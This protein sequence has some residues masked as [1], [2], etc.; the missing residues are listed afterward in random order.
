MGCAV[1]SFMRNAAYAALVCTVMWPQAARA[2][3]T[4]TCPDLPCTYPAQIGKDVTIS[5]DLITSPDIVVISMRLDIERTVGT[6]N[7]ELTIEGNDIHVYAEVSRLGY[8]TFGLGTL[9]PLSFTSVVPGISPNGELPQLTI[10]DAAMITA[11]YTS[12]L[13]SDFGG[14]SASFAGLTVGTCGGEGGA[15][16][17]PLPDDVRDLALK[18]DGPVTSG[19]ISFL[20]IPIPNPFHVFGGGGESPEIEKCC[21]AHDICYINGG[22][23][24]DEDNCDAAFLKCV[25]ANVPWY[26]SGWAAAVGGVMMA[27]S[28][29]AFK[30]NPK[31]CRCVL[32]MPSEAPTGPVTPGSSAGTVKDCTGGEPG[33]CEGGETTTPTRET[34]DETTVTALPEHDAVIIPHGDCCVDGECKEEQACAAALMKNVPGSSTAQYQVGTIPGKCKSFEAAA[35]Q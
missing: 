11:F 27:T 15:A 6:L 35:P 34:T 28:S 19:G 22:C 2:Q 21:Q 17:T 16:C 32:E 30:L 24:Q 20:P 12:L 33:Q 10:N 1:F 13:A 3:S 31:G 14:A 26:D 9:D 8:N 23:S 25:M 29:S 5:G 18:C 7:M 4:V